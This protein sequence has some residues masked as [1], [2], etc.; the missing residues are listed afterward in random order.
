MIFLGHQIEGKIE[1]K[2]NGAFKRII[3]RHHELISKTY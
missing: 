1:G 3:K 2:V